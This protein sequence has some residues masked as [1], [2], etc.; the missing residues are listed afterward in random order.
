MQNPANNPSNIG[1]MDMQARA[2]FDSM[3]QALKSQIVESGAK[4][5]TKEELEQYCKNALGS[6]AQP[7]L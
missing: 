5:C 3:P 1:A 2:Y 4:L 6:S 7:G